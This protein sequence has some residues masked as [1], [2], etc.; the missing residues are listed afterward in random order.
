[1]LGSITPL[2]ERGRGRRWGP[3]VAIYAIASTV[4][5][6]ILGGLLGALGGIAAGVGPPGRAGL[7]GLGIVIL[8][9]VALDM[10]IVGPR[11]PSLHRQ[12]NEDWLRRYRGWVYAAGFGFQLGLG[13]VTIVSIS[14]VYLTFVAALLSGS[15][16]TGLLIGGSF[17]LLRAVPLMA[18]AR[19][20]LPRHLARVDGVLRRWDRPVRKVAVGVEAGLAAVALSAGLV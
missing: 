9:G 10:G 3:T 13:V 14:S 2:G 16:P 7:V 6:A 20:R 12:V 5:G 4:G 17:G 15:A 18:T 19:V 11:L 1:M 8:I